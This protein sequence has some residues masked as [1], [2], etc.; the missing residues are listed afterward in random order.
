MDK[1]QFLDELRLEVGLVSDYAKNINE[2][3]RGVVHAIG[4]HAKSQSMSVAIFIVEQESFVLYEC[5]GTCPYPPIEKFGEGQLSLCAIRGGETVFSEETEERML[6]PFYSGHHLLGIL[7]L[8]VPSYEY[9][10]TEEDLVFLQ[11][12]S[13]YMTNKQTQFQRH[14]S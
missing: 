13:N 3:Y 11:E 12:V 14:N 5:I 2:F 9:S 6:T 1:S 7:Y 8:S 4:N 10:I